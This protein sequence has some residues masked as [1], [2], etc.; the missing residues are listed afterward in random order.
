MK[1]L[2]MTG[3]GTPDVLSVVET[4]HPRAAAHEILVRVAAAAV[5]PVDL[6]VRRGDIPLPVLPAVVGW[7]VS[8]TVVDAGSAVTR[9]REGD[10]IVAARSALAAGAGVTAEFV[11]LD[12]T[13]AAHAPAGTPLE[14]AAALPLA[15][16]TAEQALDRLGAGFRGRLLVSGAAGAVGGHLVRLADLRG[17]EPAALARHDDAEAVAALGAAEVFSD[18]GNRPPERAF[19]AVIDAAGTPWTAGTVRDG[20]RFVSLTPFAVPEA[21]RSVDVEI[22]GVRTD[23]AMLHTLA[24]HVEARRLPLRIAHTLPFEEG[25]RAHALLEKGGTRGKILL[26]PAG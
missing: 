25:P 1:A 8:G 12:E 3:Y 10:R 19:D 23:G 22:Y 18:T 13:L 7:D 16:L 26:T 2:V 24:R 17:W 5:N 11:A 14:H 21:E 6:A 4:D 20:G 15:A 9:F